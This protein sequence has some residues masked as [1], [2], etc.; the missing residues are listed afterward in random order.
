MKR[1]ITRGF[2]I[3]AAVLLAVLG[4]S[5]GPAQAGSPHFI[6]SATT[7]TRTGDDLTVAG[8]IAGLGSETAV[9][10]S[11]SADAQC[12]NN[13]G[14]KPRAGNKQSFS[15]DGYFPVQNGKAIFSLT[16]VA[17]FSPDCSPPMTVQWSN[18]VLTDP[19]HDL[20]LKFPGTF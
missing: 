11:V 5:V 2:I 15:V 18:V 10:I 7:I 9:F 16:L 19:E 20:T 4:L 1:T 13:G 12:V 3:A 8:K 17:S 6:K 14:N